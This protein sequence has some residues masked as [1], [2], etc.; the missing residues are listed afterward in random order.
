MDPRS[1]DWSELVRRDFERIKVTL[2][3]EEIENMSEGQYKSF[4]KRNMRMTA[5]EDLK[6]KQRSLSKVKDIQYDDFFKPQ[7]YLIHSSFSDEMR[8]LLY[9]LR[10]KSVRGFKDNFHGMFHNNT[11]DLCGYTCDSQQHTIDCPVLSVTKNS[12]TNITYAHIYGSIDQQ[13]EVVKLFKTLL[14][15]REKLLENIP[16]YRG[17]FLNP[18]SDRGGDVNTGPD[19]S[20][21]NS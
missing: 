21:F 9:N 12:N 8:S 1:D 2:S 5:F 15:K 4:I 11:C 13:L 6:T 18:K 20:Y 16:A 7:E 19:N 3:E 10:C 17:S 14:E